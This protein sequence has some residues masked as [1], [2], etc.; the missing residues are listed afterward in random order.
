MD[1]FHQ[2]GENGGDPWIKRSVE[3]HVPTSRL[4]EKPQNGQPEVQRH[5]GIRNGECVA[6]A[7]PS[8]HFLKTTNDACSLSRSPNEVMQT[9]SASFSPARANYV[10]KP[11]QPRQTENSNHNL[12]VN[13]PK[14]LQNRHSFSTISEQ[15]K[16]ELQL[17]IRRLSQQMRQMSLKAINKFSISD[18]NV[19]KKENSYQEAQTVGLFTPQK[20]SHGTG[21]TDSKEISKS[22]DSYSSNV[23]TILGN[24]KIYASCQK[25]NSMQ[26]TTC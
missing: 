22:K 21:N 15:S 5:Q 16:E 10:A 19:S 14:R 18:C 2:I 23:S 4:K 11:D 3:S 17:N 12:S 25:S 26:E 20:E 13:N 1:G 8:P 24:T 7:P 6:S 9:K